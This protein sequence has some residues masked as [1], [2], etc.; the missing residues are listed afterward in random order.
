MSTNI[1]N[2]SNIGGL[3]DLGQYAADATGGIF[4]G[5][6]MIALFSIIM[7]NTR[8]NGTANSVVVAGFACFLLSI[9]LLNLEFVQ[10]IYPVFF[11]AATA[12]GVFYKVFNKQG[13]ERV[14]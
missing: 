6:I 12:G 7:I 14:Y 4:W 5:V 8:R 1:T 3:Y 10:L 9:I 2:I 11:G 13:N